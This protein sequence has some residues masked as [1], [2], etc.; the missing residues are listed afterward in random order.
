MVRIQQPNNNHDNLSGVSGDDH[1]FPPLQ[2]IYTGLLN[3]HFMPGW[4]FRTRSTKV[5]VASRAEYIPIYFSA[6]VHV[7]EISI[8]VTGAGAGGTIARLGLYTNGGQVAIPSV[9]I[10][11]YGTV[12]VASTGVKTITIDQTLNIGLYYLVVV[13]DGT[14]T[15][16]SI[17]RTVPFSPPYSTMSD[18]FTGVQ[19]SLQVEAGVTA[20]DALA[21]IA[22]YI[23]TAVDEDMPISMYQFDPA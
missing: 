17:D 15:I 2:N 16:E 9:L 18:G 7:D 6:R 4:W 1:H 20:T 14:P 22:G 3:S 21:G 8:R 5:L 12:S 23:G 11:D 19:E 10:T 13:S